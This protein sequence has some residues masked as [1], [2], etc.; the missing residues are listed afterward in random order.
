MNLRDQRL[1]QYTEYKNGISIE[2]E[3][4]QKEI[5][6]QRNECSTGGDEDSSESYVPPVFISGK[7][8]MKSFIQSIFT[9]TKN[10]I[11]FTGIWV[12]PILFYTGISF[13]E[14][15][16]LYLLLIAFILETSSSGHF[17]ISA[18]MEQIRFLRSVQA[19]TTA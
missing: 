3:K 10:L 1:L 17:I 13:T 14:Y 18:A 4:Q 8:K 2:T 7:S 9:F 5:K 15:Q 19:F 11:C 16:W 6:K 12:W